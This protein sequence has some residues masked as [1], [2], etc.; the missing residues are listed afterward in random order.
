MPLVKVL[1]YHQCVSIDRNIFF[2]IPLKILGT[3]PL[4]LP[5][6]NTYLNYE[7]IEQTRNV[8]NLRKTVQV[9]N[10]HMSSNLI[11]AGFIRNEKGC[12]S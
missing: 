1:M 7:L 5:L 9:I 11:N 3:L 4:P 6:S 2:L 10:V 8:V 12:V